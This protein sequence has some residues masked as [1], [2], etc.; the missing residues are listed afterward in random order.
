MMSVAFRELVKPYVIQMQL[1][2]LIKSV[3]IESVVLAAEVIRFA[4][5]TKPVLTINV[6][7]CL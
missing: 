4:I 6:K 2:V 7:V 5:K 1:V 3:P